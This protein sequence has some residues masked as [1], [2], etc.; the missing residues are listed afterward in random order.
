MNPAQ[1]VVKRFGGPKV[2]ADILGLHPNRVSA[3]QRS[4]Q[5]GGAD[6]RIPGQ[7]QQPLLDF[8]R[9]NGIDLSPADFFDLPNETAP[10][11]SAA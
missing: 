10:A 11:A 6:G 9:A 8:A 1:R 4:K 7:H 3:W 2:V 5:S